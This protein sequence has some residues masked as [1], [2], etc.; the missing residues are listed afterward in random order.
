METVSLLVGPGPVAAA[1]GAHRAVE[2]GPTAAEAEDMPP[3]GSGLV[4]RLAS[5]PGPLLSIGLVVLALLACRGLYGDGRLMG[6]AL[7]PT[8]DSAADESTT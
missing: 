2:S 8:P 7:L 5:R 4:R 6:G 3:W 1:G